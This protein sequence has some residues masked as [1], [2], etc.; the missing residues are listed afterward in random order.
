MV[1][2]RVGPEV[3]RVPGDKVGA[4]VGPDVSRGAE[5]GVE[6]RTGTG[7]GTP[8]GAR[9]GERSGAIVVCG[10]GPDDMLGGRVAVGPDVG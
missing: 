4:R 7:V 6:D 2:V 5:A 8:V 3:T 1:G 9:D 10:G